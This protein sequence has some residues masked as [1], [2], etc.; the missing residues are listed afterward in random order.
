VR[1]LLPCLAAATAVLALTA[2]G[3]TETPATVTVTAPPPIPSSTTPPVIQVTLPEVAGQNGAIVAEQLTDLGL[4]N[5]QLASQD[6]LDKFVVNPANWTAVE[7]APE[8]GTVVSSDSTVV[9]TMTK[10]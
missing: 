5:F 10:E 3:G 7:I 6:E 8:A 2:C 4:T 9:V 1:S